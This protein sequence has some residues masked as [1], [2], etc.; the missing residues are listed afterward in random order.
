GGY[1]SFYIRFEAVPFSVIVLSN[2][3]PHNAFQKANAI[4][5]QYFQVENREEISEEGETPA[6]DKWESLSPNTDIIEQWSG[7]YYNEELFSFLH[8]Q[9]EA[10]DKRFRV[11]W[12]ENRD[13]GYLSSL[14]NDS[15]LVE[16]EDSNYSYELSLPDQRLINKNKEVVDRT[17]RKVPAPSTPLT[18]WAG[19]YFCADIQHRLSLSVKDSL[20]VSNTPFVTELIYFGEGLFRDNSTFSLVKFEGPEKF[21]LNIPQGDRNL[22]HLEFNRV[23][24]KPSVQNSKTQ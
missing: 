20:L 11:N 5:D 19:T 14:K 18:T 22:R 9:Y 21:T 6:P 3:D 16:Q 15:T 7:Y 4:V 24:A 2:S 17:W 13:G 10:A 8:I 23:E 1:R 12:L